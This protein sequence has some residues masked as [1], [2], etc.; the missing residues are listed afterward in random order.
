MDALGD[1]EIRIEG[2]VGAR[3][4]T[5]TLVDIDEIREILTQA[6][7]LLFPTEKRSQRPL[8]SYEIVEGSVRH[9][10][11]TVMQSVIGFGA[12]L[13]QISSQGQIDFLHERSAVAIERFQHLAVEKDYVVTISANESRLVV[14]RTTH[15]LRNAKLWVDAEFY[16]Y[17]ELT[18]AGGKSSPNIHLDTE[19][20]GTLRI[21]TDKDYLKG[22]DKNLLYKKFGLRVT[23]KQNLQTFEMDRNSLT[24]VDLFDYDLEYSDAYLDGLMKKAAPSWRMS[25]TRTGGWKK[26]VEEPMSKLVLKLGILCDTGFLIRLSQPNDDLHA[27]ARGYLKNLLAGGHVLYVS[28]IALAE[29]AVRDKIENLPMKYFRVIPFNIDHAQRAGEFANTVFSKRDQIPSEITQR[30]IIPND[31]KMFAQADVT[32]AITHY[33]TADQKCEV[34]YRLVQSTGA[35]RFQILSL[36]TPYHVAFGELKLDD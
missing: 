36:R 22:A 33:L 1:I 25:L 27:N 26:S 18:N 31:T 23:G 21:S 16:L 20:F 32:N 3:K 8:I 34:V 19:E 11:R 30:V 13:S 29:Y 15:Y 2:S 6:S 4:L 14:D 17:G 7:G 9:K 35:M 5:P 24:F 10:F 12:V 28:T